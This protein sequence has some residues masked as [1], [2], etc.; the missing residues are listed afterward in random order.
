MKLKKEIEMAKPE[1]HVA[2]YKKRI[3]KELVELLESYPTVGVVDLMYLPAS[4][5]K[6]IR[7]V[8][9][10]KVLIKVA[11][12]RLIGLAL[13]ALSRK[14]KGIDKLK[15]YLQGIC[16]LVFS[17]ENP[18]V[19]YKLIQKNKSKAPA[20][21]GQ[22]APNDIIVKAGPTPFTP[23]PIIGELGALGIKTK[24]EGGKVNIVEDKVVVKEGEVISEKV[25]EIL[26]R[27]GIEPMEI[28]LN[29]IAVYENG[30]IYEKDVLAVDEEKLMNDLVETFLIAKSL[31]KEAGY[32]V[33]EVVE[34]MI[35]ECF[36]LCK[37][38]ALESWF[39]CP[40]TIEDSLYAGEKYALMLADKI[41]W[42]V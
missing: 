20:K 23:G 4:Q 25:A 13:D 2:E 18:F 26:K 11:K 6:R 37:A 40:E 9:R 14:K 35:A 39:V 27:L 41:K 24:V 8:L 3:V 21:A 31:A 38:V 7:N 1:A 15:D 16:A 32:F 28:G 29:V 42:E 12:K 33:K 34:E 30:L 5:L 17:T 22:I 10:G 19:L 36:N